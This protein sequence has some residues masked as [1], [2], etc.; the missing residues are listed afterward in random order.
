MYEIVQQDGLFR[1]EC[2][3]HGERYPGWHSFEQ[4]PDKLKG[5]LAMLLAA[6]DGQDS[7]HLPD[8]GEKTSPNTFLI[9]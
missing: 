9:Y 5:K 7:G 2:E 3:E 4:L 8:I 1:I 6:T